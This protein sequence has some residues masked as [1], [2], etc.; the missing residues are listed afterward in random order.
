MFS[1]FDFIYIYQ[2]GPPKAQAMTGL[3]GPEDGRELKLCQGSVAN[4]E[5]SC[6]CDSPVA[7]LQQK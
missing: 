5:F 7:E 1:V 2:W 3:L 4:N 6:L